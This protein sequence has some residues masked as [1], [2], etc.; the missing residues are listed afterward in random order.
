MLN[1][2]FLKILEMEINKCCLFLNTYIEA[3]IW[4]DQFTAWQLSY[5][6]WQVCINIKI[7]FSDKSEGKG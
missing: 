5:R 4:F 3:K 6:D 1:M 2:Q 7:R